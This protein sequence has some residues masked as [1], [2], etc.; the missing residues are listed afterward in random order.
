MAVQVPRYEQG[1]VQQRVAPSVRQQEA[2]SGAFGGQVGD[3]LQ[4][5][6]GMLGKIAEQERQRIDTAA[7]ME[8]EAELRGT[9]NTLLF[10]DGSGQNRG[11][12][13][14]TGKD[15]FGLPERV[16]P[17][18]DK[19]RQA[20][21]GRLSGRQR[22]LFE[23][24]TAD[25]G[26]QTQGDL[27]RHVARESERYTAETTKAYIESAGQTALL[28]YTD[29]VKIDA[30][31]QRAQDAYI[32]GNPGEPPEA[33][34]V[35]L[36]KI[37]STVRKGV[38]ERL[39]VESPSR[40][41]AY[42][43]QNRERFT[44]E[45]QAAIERVLVPVWKA[46]RG[47]QIGR[48]ALAGG[49]VATAG[50]YAT[51]R[52]TLES[53]GRADARNPNSSAT[54]AD[55][56]TESTWLRM[57]AN[58]QPAWAAGKSRQ[59]I[60][61][62]RMDPEKSGQMAEALD[63]ESA[64]ALAAAGQ[65]ATN[66]NLY[67]A[68]HFGA[69]AGVKFARASGDTPIESVL[70]ADAIA[71]NPYLRGKTKAQVVANWNARAGASG[72]TG[73]I[74]ATGAPRSYADARQFVLDTVT[75]D[76]ERKAALAYIDVQ[77][78]IERQR[79]AEVERNLQR[80]ISTK[81]EQ[82]DPSTPFAKVVTPSELAEAQARGWVSSYEARLK[83][84]ID[85]QD[86]V[87]PPD[88][89]LA[90]RDIVARAAA[91]DRL[92]Q[93]E[94]AKY[95]PYDPKIQMSVADRDWLWKSQAAIAGNDPAAKAKAAT[96]GEINQVIKHYTTTALGVPENQIGKDSEDGKRAWRFYNDL[97]SWVDRFERDKGRSPSFTE[98]QQQADQMTLTFTRQE[99]T[100]YGGTRAVEQTVFDLNIPPDKVD[101]IASALRAADKPVTG[102]NI[103]T[104][105]QSY[106]R[107]NRAQ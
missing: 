63:R 34:K 98:V 2:P 106:L 26:A 30:E 1:Q 56:F 78:Q 17:E 40:A 92:A 41:Q 60:L 64:K 68:H 13:G 67:A 65:P 47:E 71:A 91:G 76:T 49:A 39:I 93:S 48:A 20:I 90:Y 58:E 66:E 36:N 37:D 25:W 54:G 3:A 70:S 29:P 82:A 16:L 23:Q 51:Y 89:L 9:Q 74:A 72:G 11:A 31:I 38:V 83:Q 105:W 8:A 32:V 88:Q 103:A 101:Q 97:R 33:T 22:E 15:A 79:E 7:V 21:A 53:G 19:R 10:G 102:Q 55:Q 6:G 14:T 87:T 5:A 75:D 44:G 62:M 42:Y 100:W 28:Y 52:R 45:D 77:Q 107:D 81:V 96:E 18:L 99:S 12:Y 35:A 86:A 59:E 27:L 46:D 80:S 73:A 104:M 43:Q 57:V 61:N 24:R 94:L 95:K 85:G 84:R 50:D 69:G 4:R